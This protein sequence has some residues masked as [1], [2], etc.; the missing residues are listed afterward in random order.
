MTPCDLMRQ[1]RCVLLRWFPRW[2]FV[3][4]GDSG[5]G[6]HP[7]ARFVNRQP[8]L[9]LISKFYKDA[10]LYDPPPKRQPGTNG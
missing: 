8:R 10:N 1:L 5:F 2:K 9:T 7:L 3:F 6:S 4:G